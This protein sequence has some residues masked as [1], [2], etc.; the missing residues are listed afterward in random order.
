MNIDKVNKILFEQNHLLSSIVIGENTDAILDKVC[1]DVESSLDIEGIQCAVFE[2][3]NKH[4][5][6]INAPKQTVKLFKNSQPLQLADFGYE[7]P[8]TTASSLTLTNC[9][10]R[11]YSDSEQ[12]NSEAPELQGIVLPLLSLN[13]DLLGLLVIFANEQLYLGEQQKQLFKLFGNIASA[14]MEARF[15]K[16][17]IDLHVEKLEKSNEKFRAF[18][19]VMPDIALIIS[20]EGVYEDVHGSPDNLI[21]ISAT[22]LI[23]RNVFDIF[24]QADAKNVMKVIK[25]ALATNSIQE[26]EY[27][28]G[29]EE[30]TSIFEGRVVPINYN[31]DKSEKPLHVLWMARDVTTEK[32]NQKKITQLAYFDPLTQLPNRRMFNERLELT[33]ESKCLTQ[34]FGAILFLDLDDFKR[35]NDSLGHVAGDSLLKDVSTR[36]KETLRK[37]DTLA[38]IGGD[39]FVILIENIG[40]SIEEAEEEIAIVAKKIQDAFV[41]KFEVEKLSF[42][43]SSSIGICFIDGNTSAQNIM[44]FADTAMY[45]SK[46]QGGDSYSFYDPKK[47]TLLDRQ[48]TFE[49]EIVNA[50]EKREFCTYF[51]PQLNKQ[52]TLCGAEALIRWIHPEKGLIPPDEF[53]SVAE[54]FGLIQSLQDIVLEDMCKLVNRLSAEDLLGDIF[55]LSINISHLQFRSPKFQEQLTNTID[56]FGVAANKIILE[57]TESMLSHDIEKTVQQMTNIA[58]VGFAFSIDD[59]G[60]GYSNLSNLHA[61]PVEELKIDKSFIDR[62]QDSSGLSIVETIINLAKNLGMRVVAEGVENE[63]QLELLKQQ[64]VDVLQGYHISKPLPVDVYIT[65]HKNHFQPS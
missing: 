44:K 14:S 27:S 43:V 3:Q 2:Y 17:D 52:G 33:V 51:Q 56:V 23:N 35:I 63:H 65:W 13:S 58:S 37:S 50:I 15:K 38:R 8:M 46:R 41:Q 19:Q 31:A 26:Y 59:F 18:T 10:L 20:E 57:I 32:K 11:L 5:T 30:G 29:E 42:R 7:S 40:H 61:F 34:E 54:Q 48:L 6:I 24:P 22:E 39:E 60:T 47:Q 28:V 4:L 25:R 55:R 53:I 64:N 12:N 9:I 62:M 16:R 45:N 36:L 21:Y 49:S 1:F